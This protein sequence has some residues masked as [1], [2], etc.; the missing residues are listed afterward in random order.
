[1][2]AGLANEMVTGLANEMMTA[3][4]VYAA[5]CCYFCSYRAATIRMQRW[6]CA[7]I[8]T[9]RTVVGRLARWRHPAVDV[10]VVMTMIAVLLSDVVVVVVVA[11]DFVEKGL[12]AR[13][14]SFQMRDKLS[15]LHRSS[16]RRCI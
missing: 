13:R 9:S 11:A 10:V 6:C 3:I 7:G 8:A 4:V 5:A 2:A 16:R 15:L 1:M 14:W 12:T